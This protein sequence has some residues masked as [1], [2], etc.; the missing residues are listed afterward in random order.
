MTL[1]M[2]IE[3]KT[4]FLWHLLTS[5]CDLSLSLLCITTSYFICLSTTVSLTSFFYISV[6]FSVVVSS[7][8]PDPST[9]AAVAPTGPGPAPGCSCAAFSQ[10]AEQ[11]HRGQH[12]SLRSHTYYPAAP[13]A[14]HPARP[15]KPPA[16]LQIWTLG[17]GFKPLL[18]GIPF[19]RNRY[20]SRI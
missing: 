15:C 18:I 14:A 11:H 6:S 20:N 7:V 5:L 9:A 13:V 17:L 2:G 8:D 16:F 1:F 19:S 4:Q 12:L 3:A 10:P